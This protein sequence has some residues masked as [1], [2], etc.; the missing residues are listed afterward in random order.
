MTWNEWIAEGHLVED[1]LKQERAT[2]P[3]TAARR[4]QIDKRL[5]ILTILLQLAQV[6]P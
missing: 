6:D 1:D 2:L 4:L 3:T 5:S